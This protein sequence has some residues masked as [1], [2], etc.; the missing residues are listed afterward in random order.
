MTDRTDHPLRDKA[1]IV[2]VGY[3]EFSKASGVSTL[4]LAL[5]AIAAAVGDAGLTVADVDGVAC[6]RVGDSAPAALVAQSLGLQDLRFHYDIFGGGSVSAG[7][8]AGAAMAVATGQADC[9]VC[10]RA[11][12][13]RSGHRMGGTGR[14]APDT[15]EFQYLAPYGHVTPPQHFAMYARAYMH[16]FGVTAED[17]GRVA[18]LQREN[19]SKSPRAMM[20]TPLTMEEYLASR[21][22]VEPFR[23]YDCCLETDAA[24]ALVV[25]SADRARHL[26]HTPVLVSGAT[27]G[28]GHN[29][30]SNRSEWS[31]SGAAAMSR[32]LYEMAGIGPG[33]DRRCRTVRRVHVARA[34]PAGGL[35]LLPAGGGGA[36]VADGHTALGGALPVN[37]HGGHLSEGYVHGLNHVAEAVTQLRWAADAR[38]VPGAEVALSTGQPGYVAGTSSALLLRRA[39]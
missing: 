26:P 5:R 27:H 37:T 32:R 29:W 6:H 28:G 25:M 30:F 22:V 39:S 9:V 8:V 12:N 18:V 35:R 38:Q 23:L 21:W 19:A 24:V 16:E 13:A 14:G 34:P 33:R 2:G 11:I 17:L 36:F 4:T 7:V 31:P 1:A 20:R 15:P 10:W 3:T